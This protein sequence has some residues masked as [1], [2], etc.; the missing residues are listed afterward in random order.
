MTECFL[1]Y[2][3]VFIGE[4]KI[5][6]KAETMPYLALA[7]AQGIRQC[8]THLYRQQ[9]VAQSSDPLNLRNPSRWIALS[10]LQGQNG[11][12]SFIPVLNRVKIVKILQ[13]WP[14]LRV[15]KEEKK[16]LLKFKINS[17]LSLFEIQYENLGAIKLI[18]TLA[19]IKKTGKLYKIWTTLVRFHKHS[20]SN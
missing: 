4:R 11:R 15:K 13:I 7:S 1:V 3:M 19:N 2:Q 10:F 14:L 16:F 6:D 20:P 12:N 18:S 5:C 9:L 17:C 8:S